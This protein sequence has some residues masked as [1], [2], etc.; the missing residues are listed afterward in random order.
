VYGN[1]T[2]GIKM[3][4]ENLKA[5]YP[6]K[7]LMVSYESL[8][9]FLKIAVPTFDEV[10]VSREAGGE[11]NPRFQSLLETEPNKDVRALMEDIHLRFTS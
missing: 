4:L 2:T 11:Y 9:G 6:V 5:I 7:T 3:I 8:R 10:K 1:D